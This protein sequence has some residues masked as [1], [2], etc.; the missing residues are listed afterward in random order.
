MLD[1]L[2]NVVKEVNAELRGQI[3]AKVT[4]FKVSLKPKDTE[5]VEEVLKKLEPL[6][7]FTKI[8]NFTDKGY[9]P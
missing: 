7:K 8:S 3:P 2:S 1:I 9:K 6:S 5:N 4:A